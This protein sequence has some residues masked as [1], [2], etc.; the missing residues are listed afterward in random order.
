M[1][2]AKLTTEISSFMHYTSFQCETHK[3]EMEKKD[4]V[5]KEKRGDSCGLDK[6]GLFSTRVN[7]VLAIS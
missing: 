3:V 6:Q 1:A 7:V 2:E 5:H 4:T